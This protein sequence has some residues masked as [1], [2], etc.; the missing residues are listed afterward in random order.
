MANIP[1]GG[2]LRW[3]NKQEPRRLHLGHRR[4]PASLDLPPAHTT[5]HVCTR[6]TRTTSKSNITQA[7]LTNNSMVGATPFRCIPS[8]VRQV[9]G[10]TLSR[11][12]PCRWNT[13][14]RGGPFGYYLFRARPLFGM[15][16][17]GCAPFRVG[18]LSGAPLFGCAPWRVRPTLAAP[19][20][21]VCPLLGAPF[22]L[23]A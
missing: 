14:L 7:M 18:S 13:L 1:W 11:A 21:W 6:L 19:M 16:P 5:Q 22:G 12:P 2:R 10:G 9:L 3:G 4:D 17:R 15:P 23:L 20:F 8:W